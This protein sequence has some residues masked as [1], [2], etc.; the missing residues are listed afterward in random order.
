[1]IEVQRARVT[2]S[3]GLFANEKGVLR[4]VTGWAC[5]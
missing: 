2:V 4:D 3:V 5:S 1:M